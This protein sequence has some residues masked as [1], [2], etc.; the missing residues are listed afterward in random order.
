[1]IF[2]CFDDVTGDGGIV[3]HHEV[4]PK[5]IRI[6]RGR[7]SDILRNGLFQRGM[8]DNLANDAESPRD[9]IG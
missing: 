7:F 6:S 4:C 2:K 1:M 5:H 3:M 9:I 8:S